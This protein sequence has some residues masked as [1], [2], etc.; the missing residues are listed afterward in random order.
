MASSMPA[1]TRPCRAFLTGL[2]FIERYRHRPDSDGNAGLSEQDMVMS[3]F[4]YVDRIVGQIVRPKKLLF[5]AVDGVAP[6]AKLNQQ[7]SRRFGAAKETKAAKDE[8]TVH[9]E[10]VDDLNP[11]D[12]NCITPG[13][14]FMARIGEKL[15]GYIRQKMAR[16]PAWSRLAVVFSGADV[17]GEGEH[18]IMQYIRS[19]RDV[20]SNEPTRHCMYGNDA[21]LIMLALA[22]HEP[23]FTLLREVIDFS[24]NKRERA[25]A[26]NARS[27]IVRQSRS[28]DF[29]L[30]HL[31]IL[32][33]YIQLEFCC[34]PPASYASHIDTKAGVG[35]HARRS[36]PPARDELADLWKQGVAGRAFDLER[37]VDDFVFLTFFVG[38]DFLPHSPSL[39]IGEHAFNRIFDAYK[40]HLAI[41]PDGAY[42][43]DAGSIVDAQRLQCFISELGAMEPAILADRR[44]EAERERNRFQRG[45]NSLAMGDVDTNGGDGIPPPGVADSDREKYY[46]RTLG[47]SHLLDERFESTS[48]SSAAKGGN[49]SSCISHSDWQSALDL[50]SGK[51]YCYNARTQETAW[52]PMKRVQVAQI[53]NSNTVVERLSAAFVEGLAWCLA[54]YVKGC[55]DWRWFYPCHYCPMLAD[56][57]DVVGA[58]AGLHFEIGAPLRPLEQLMS[59]LPPGSAQ[60]LPR[61]HRSLMLKE[62]S[63]LAGFYPSDFYVDMDGKRNPWEGV[64][65]LPFIEADCLLD[66]VEATCEDSNLAAEERRR[67][68]FGRSIVFTANATSVTSTPPATKDVHEGTNN[69]VVSEIDEHPHVAEPWLVCGPPLRAVLPAGCSKPLP[70]F[71]SLHAIPVAGAVLRALKL[72]C[73]GS[74]SRYETMCLRMPIPAPDIAPPDVAAASI[75]AA[76][77]GKN[78]FV[79]WPMTHEARLVAVTGGG[80]RYGLGDRDSSTVLIRTLDSMATSNFKA[81]SADLATRALIGAGSPGD[82]GL[83]VGSID[84]VLTVRLLQ[85][86]A[87]DAATGALLKVYG[88]EET[89]IPLQLALS[90]PPSAHV[91]DPRFRETAANPASKRFK[92]GSRVLL[93]SGPRRGCVGIVCKCED[94]Q[95]RVTVAVPIDDV[96]PQ[97][98]LAI[99]AALA[100]KFASAKLAANELGLR[101]DVLAAC[102]GSILARD[103][104]GVAYDLGLRLYVDGGAFVALGYC[105]AERASETQTDWAQAGDSLTES[106]TSRFVRHLCFEYSAKAIRLVAAY[107][108]RFPA[109]FDA[110]ADA[111]SGIQNT[112]VCAPV[113]FAGAARIFGHDEPD[114]RLLEA[115]KWLAGLPIATTARVPTSTVA[116]SPGAVAAVQR[117]ATK[118]A[119]IRSRAASTRE[120]VVVPAADVRAEHEATD[121]ASRAR[122]F[123]MDTSCASPRLG[124]RVVA[125]NVGQIGAPFGQRGTIIAI[126]AHS[127]AVDVVFDTPFVGGT[128]LQGACE[129]F[130]GLLCPWTALL[131]IREPTPDDRSVT[132]ASSVR[133]DNISPPR[134]VAKP[135][136]KLKDNRLAMGPDT[137]SGFAPTRSVGRRAVQVL[138]KSQ[139]PVS[140]AVAPYVA[141]AIILAPEGQPPTSLTRDM[142]GGRVSPVKTSVHLAASQP[143]LTTNDQNPGRLS[144]V[145]PSPELPTSVPASFLNQA[146]LQNIGLPEPLT[147][148]RQRLD[149]T[150]RSRTAH[151][152]TPVDTTVSTSPTVTKNSV[153][154]S[155]GFHPLGEVGKSKKKKMGLT[156]KTDSQVNLAARIPR[157]SHSS[158][159]PDLRVMLP[160]SLL[161]KAPMTAFGRVSR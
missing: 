88:R 60:L 99:A 127:A 3:I 93:R 74:P 103:G 84:V 44:R 87:R 76:L 97:F 96:E 34:S 23:N 68:G 67:A 120:T 14:A 42:L 117:A 28:S 139:P 111:L 101:E 152:A 149:S 92:T 50:S 24:A 57:V 153:D 5:L 46:L 123:D 86:L 11:F 29:Q 125:C 131:S 90:A 63:P 77:L 158:T 135:Q 48:N 39:D 26:I 22:T 61:P 140:Q 89:D 129:N 83:D 62:T 104:H 159:P 148:A 32:R 113:V 105:R 30:L 53:Q 145:P 13:T 19:H 72:D 38:N 133:P 141:T 150:G 21:D 119:A 59:C 45:R 115:C 80:L 154:V 91:E 81:S 143:T 109:V 36:E 134:A 79:N 54:Y 7:R 47:I 107:L 66:I 118:R 100:D 8:A 85:G 52:A 142:S 126:H 138:A 106:T 37:L 144:T 18:K 35:P 31:S 136:G 98:G 71:P 41:W 15:R 124:E 33:E 94:S 146:P 75:A 112:D 43:T 160:T 16:D 155:Y 95:N 4:A 73:F 78:I 9:G 151:P 58:L 10:A 56:V 49:R 122:V 40:R 25:A 2:A 12:R 64:N 51:V 6:R 20:T 114:V 156:L 65:L 121:V 17:P 157:R 55:A 128:S 108:R 147:S 69:L 116:M 130:R 1:L 82:G 137:S 161:G 70:G 110:V 102:C 132:S 27:T